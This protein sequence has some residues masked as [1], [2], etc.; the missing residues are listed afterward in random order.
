MRLQ[1]FCLLFALCAAFGGFAAERPKQI[2]AH[3]MGCYPAGTGPTA[4]HRSE[5]KLDHDSP[6]FGQATGGTICNWDLVPHK[7]RLSPDASAELE[8]KRAIRGGID[9]FSLDAWAGPP[10]QK[11]RWMRCSGPPKNPAP[12]LKSRSASTP[13]ACRSTRKTAATPGRMRMPTRSSICSNGTATA[14]ISPGAT[15]SR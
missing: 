3:Y 14:R 10:E 4:H 6:A 1:S 11:P 2:F 9:G 15:E 7:T 8:V 5:L 12:I 13:P